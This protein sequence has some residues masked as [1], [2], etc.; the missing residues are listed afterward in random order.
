MREDQMIETLKRKSHMFLTGHKQA[1]FNIAMIFTVLLVFQ[2]MALANGSV[3]DGAAAQKATSLLENI[4]SIVG[5]LMAV[6]GAIVALVGIV[7]VFSAMQSGSQMSAHIYFMIGGIVLIIVG[8]AL[9]Q[10]V[11]MFIAG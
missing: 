3:L 5:K 6:G 7:N 9:P 8:M 1:I 11:K 4:L 10:L 2:N